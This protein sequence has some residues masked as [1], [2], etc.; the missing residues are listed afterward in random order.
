MLVA[1][2]E[3]DGGDAP[4]ATQAALCSG[5]KTYHL[6]VQ[7]VQQAAS[8][9]FVDAAALTHYGGAPYEALYSG[10]FLDEGAL[11]TYVSM[12]EAELGAPYADEV[13]AANEVALAHKVA[14]GFASGALAPCCSAIPCAACE[15][16][17][18]H[19]APCHKPLLCCTTTFHAKALTSCGSVWDVSMWRC[20]SLQS[21]CL[22]L[23]G[24]CAAGR[25][26]D[27][28]LHLA[29]YA[30]LQ[31]NAQAA[32]AA[33]EEPVLPLE[34]QLSKSRDEEASWLGVVP[35]VCRVEHS[36]V[37]RL[38]RLVASLRCLRATLERLPELQACQG[39]A[40]TDGD[41]VGPPDA[42]AEQ[43]CV[44]LKLLSGCDPDAPPMCLVLAVGG[45]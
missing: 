16:D 35:D 39:A 43:V 38:A 17:M 11:R 32:S 8:N 22:C 2:V 7:K 42:G 6:H 41:I 28:L 19:C 24:R 25:Q 4:G 30:L 15:S 27:G 29:Q 21:A 18:H 10:V 9:A 5:I 12:F 40:D 44:C 1:E 36:A 26:L 14:A 33:D 45:A 3:A 34:E 23:N 31:V 13:R 20:A 37:S